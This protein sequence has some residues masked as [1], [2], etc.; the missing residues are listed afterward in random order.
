MN[1][2][3][4]AL[5]SIVYRCINSLI[6][7]LI[8]T[9]I[10]TIILA[11]LCSYF[12]S[13]EYKNQSTSN[14]LA[15]VSVSNTN[16]T[17]G[18]LYGNNTVPYEIATEFANFDIVEN[19][20]FEVTGIAT[21]NDFSAVISTVQKETYSDWAELS[22]YGVTYSDQHTAFTSGEL[23]L[24]YGRHLSIEDTNKC[25]VSYNLY[26]AEDWAIG[27]VI[28]V[29]GFIPSN[30][31]ISYT[32]IVNLEIVGFYT[33][34]AISDTNDSPE[35]NYENQIFVTPETAMQINGLSNIYTASFTLNDATACDDFILEC[36]DILSEAN[37][38]LDDYNFL[39]DNSEYL[40]LDIATNSAINISKAMVILSV[41][42]G[43]IILT[44]VTVSTLNDKQFEIAILLSMGESKAKICLQMILENLFVLLCAISLS[45]LFGDIIKAKVANI[46]SSYDIIVSLNLKIV[47]LIYLVGIMIS[48]IVS[49][50]SVIKIVSCNP[51]KIL[52]DME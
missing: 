5:H 48:L 14:I 39:V 7:I 52:I 10:S 21:A 35:Y 6:L 16:K 38:N 13:I 44:L 27:D 18:T 25:I 36:S 50:V 51:K 49:C 32:D 2:L 3:K 28:E 40:K 34:S 43:I 29:I 31:G 20:N 26:D 23:T 22:I 19:Y 45:L 17:I 33:F 9:I 1:C 12:A 8:Y 30:D 37:Q 46:I 15:P 4:R 41:L 47:I 42:M 24:N 11:G